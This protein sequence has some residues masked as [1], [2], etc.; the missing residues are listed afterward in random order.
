MNFHK[1]LLVGVNVKESSLLAVVLV[2]N[3]KVGRIM[4]LYLGLPSGGNP[5]CLSFWNHLIE[6]SKQK[7]IRLEEQKSVNEQ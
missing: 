1:S 7:V 3:R 6:S 2:L 5:H 4:F